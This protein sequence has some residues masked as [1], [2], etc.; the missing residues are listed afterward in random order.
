[1]SAA[2]TTKDRA[3]RVVWLTARM[4]VVFAMGSC[5]LVSTCHRVDPADSAAS[6][7]PCLRLLMARAVMR[8]QMGIA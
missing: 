1:M 3:A 2:I 4:I 7:G 8:M 6:M 5:T